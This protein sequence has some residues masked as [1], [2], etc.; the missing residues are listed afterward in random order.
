MTRAEEYAAV[1]R[2]MEAS[3]A[4]IRQREMAKPIRLLVAELTAAKQ[5]RDIEDREAARRAW[6]GPEAG[7][8][9]RP[10]PRSS[11][12]ARNMRFT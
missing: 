6:G 3:R 7:G 12:R 2:E 1:R 9:S 10:S 11:G 8:L 4:A 5:Q